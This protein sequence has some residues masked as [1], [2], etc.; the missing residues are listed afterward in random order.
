MFSDYQQ[1]K[2]FQMNSNQR[3]KILDNLVRYYKLH[4]DGMGEIRS[5]EVLHDFFHR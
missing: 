3:K 1:I 2:G 5:L 4:V